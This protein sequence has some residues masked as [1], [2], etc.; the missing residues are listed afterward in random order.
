MTSLPAWLLVLLLCLTTYRVTRL[1]ASDAF[2]PVAAARRRLTRG[3]PAGHWLRY[4]LGDDS[5][6]GCPWCVSVWVGGAL[7]LVL[8]LYVALTLH[9]SWWPW[10]V[11]LLIWGATSAVTGTLADREK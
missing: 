6:F 2:P 8:A 4:A 1:V 5:H 11:W 9:Q 3:R 7:V 10:P